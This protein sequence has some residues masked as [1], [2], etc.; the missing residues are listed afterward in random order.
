[1]NQP[2]PEQMAVTPADDEAIAATAAMLRDGGLVAFPT[3]TVYGLGANALDPAAVARIFEAKG[4]P[5]FDPLIVHLASADDAWRVAATVPMAARRL[6][7]AF[8]P[9][10]VTLVLAKRRPGESAQALGES[11][12]T[13]VP[14]LVTAGLGTVALRVPG[15]PIARRLIEA[16]GV[17]V[18][19]PSANRFGGVSPTRAGHVAS[20]LSGSVDCILDGGACDTGVESTVVA[21]TGDRPRVLRLGGTPLEQIEA[22]VGPVE[23]GAS[24]AQPGE[25][26]ATTDQDSSAPPAPGMLDRHYSPRTRLVLVD[27]LTSER[28][29]AEQQRGEG[30]GGGRK[31]G[32]LLFADR[33]A[34]RRLADERGWISAVLSPGGDLREAAAGLFAKLRWLD[35]RGVD[36]IMAERCPERGL[37]RA[38]NDRLARAA[39]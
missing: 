6:A 13:A 34:L 17:P 19:A 38:I 36:T 32:L 37:G 30:G 14:D 39:H 23:H 35:E 15:H 4:R 24:T 10:P 5:R 7:E 11:G 28:V 8:W 1:M 21:V 20:E 18:A 33:P 26:G 25:N 12:F 31:L 29:A 9:G 22:V 27:A 16:A 3:E 2:L